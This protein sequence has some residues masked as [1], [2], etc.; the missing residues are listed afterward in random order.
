MD[1]FFGM[2]DEQFWHEPDFLL[3]LLVSFMANKLDS[4][5]GITLMVGGSVVTGTLVSERAYLQR[6]NDLFQTIVRSSMTNPSE[7]DL[8]LLEDAFGFEDMT[9]DTYPDDLEDDVEIEDAP[10]SPIRHLHLRDPYILYPGSAMTFGES[11]M[12]LLRIRLTAVDGWL[13]GR[14]NVID[15]DGDDFTPPFAGNRFKQ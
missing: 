15:G 8:N 4:E 12:P 7:D 6:M 11:P 14:V 13:P 3:G 5:F 9:E 1:N 2:D 10:Y